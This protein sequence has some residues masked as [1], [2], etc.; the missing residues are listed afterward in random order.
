MAQL[1]ANVTANFLYSATPT[2][3]AIQLEGISGQCVPLVIPWASYSNV[4][5]NIG[6]LVDLSDA[7]ITKSLASIKSVYIDNMGSTAAVYVQFPDT[8]YT[9][10]AKA[11]SAGWFPVYTNQWKCTVYAL[12]IN[13]NSIPTTKILI[14]NLAIVPNLD[15]ELEESVS[16]W[17]ASP[18]LALGGAIN[19]QYNPPALGDQILSVGLTPSGQIA[20]L[21]N[22]NFGEF[23][24]IT[25]FFVTVQDLSA[26]SQFS[27]F[28]ESTG[29]S[30]II[31]ST[32]LTIPGAATIPLATLIDCKG[33]WKLDGS[34]TY[35]LRT[36]ALSGAPGG[37]IQAYITYTIAP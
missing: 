14:S 10:V 20:N 37:L 34:Q 33:N 27:F 31:I 30:G 29:L 24:Y 35:R 6:I 26:A 8:G 5:A 17:L 18:V 15:T 32:S 36:Q 9:V 2:T 11:N 25:N 1:F 19:A 28:F 12:G 22:N 3:A 7:S 21:F 16:L 23:V 4:L 13:S